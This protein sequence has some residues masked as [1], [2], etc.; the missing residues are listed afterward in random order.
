MQGARCRVQG[1]GLAD[2]L[3]CPPIIILLSWSLMCTRRSSSMRTYNHLATYLVTLLSSHTSDACPDGCDIGTHTPWRWVAKALGSGEKCTC[4]GYT[5]WE[6]STAH[7]ET[8]HHS[9]VSGPGYIP[10]SSL[11]GY[12][13][14]WTSA[15]PQQLCVVLAQT[16]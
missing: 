10:A 2:R 15:V 7:L 8:D 9:P 12:S 5:T 3:R 6:A 4:G 1:G 16:H 13:H 14:A 11:L